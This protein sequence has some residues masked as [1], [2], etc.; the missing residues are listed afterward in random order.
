M[1]GAREAILNA[2]RRGLRR[3]PLDAERRAALERR[4]VE[5]PS[6]L[7]PAIA[8]HDGA[9]RVRRFV[10]RAEAEFA[11]V[12]R[13]AGPAAVPGAIAAYLAQR[14]LPSTAV[15]A[16][17]QWL[18]RVPWEDEPLLRL[19]KGRAE[20]D[21]AVSVT[22]AFAGIA[23]TGTLMLASGPA[24]PTTLNLLP[25]THIAVLRESRVVASYEEAWQRLREETGRVGAGLLPRNVMWVTGPSRSADIEQ[26][27]ELGVHG[28]RRVHIVLVAEAGEGGDGGGR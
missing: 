2:I 21:D 22:T 10:E 14:N 23:E 25:E 18:E 8:R 20:A 5:H 16:P 26:T 28:P 11:T 13:I 17:D 1:A 9:E 4:L 24:S 3:G 19:R 7:L 27:I 12:A 15:M 6:H